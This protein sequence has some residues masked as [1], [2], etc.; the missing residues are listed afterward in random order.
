ML[1]PAFD[2]WRLTETE[3]LVST[4]RVLGLILATATSLV[5]LKLVARITGSR[6]L[7]MVAAAVI[8]LDPTYSFAKVSAV[9]PALFGFLALAAATAF[10]CNRLSL[11][12]GLLGLAVAARPEGLLLVFLALGALMLRVWWDR[13][14]LRLA[15]GEDIPQALRV[16]GLPLLVALGIAAHNAA[17]NGDV[18]PNSY[19]VRHVPMGLFDGGN[20]FNV[21]RGYLWHT[22]YFGGAGSLVM[23]LLLVLSGISALRQAVFRAIPLILFPFALYY[24]LSV[25]VPLESRPWGIATRRYLDPTLPFI[26]VGLVVGIHSAWGLLRRLRRAYTRPS[27]GRLVSLG[28]RPLGLAAALAFLGLVAA[29]VATMPSTW[30]SLTQEFAWN[31]RNV[32]YVNVAMARWIDANLPPDAV[33]GAIDPGAFRYFSNRQVVDLTGVNTYA[34]I[35]K[36]LFEAARQE[37]VDY[38]VARRNLYLDSWPLGREVFSLEDPGRT[39]RGTPSMV[40][41]Q[42]LW[43]REVTLA[44]DSIPHITHIAGLVLLDTVDVGQPASE[45]GHLYRAAPP[46][47]PVERVSRLRTRSGSEI[48]LRDDGRTTTGREELVVRS[49]PGQPLIVVKRYDAALAGDMNVYA[50]G[51][52]VGQWRPP[53]QGYVFGEDTFRIAATH[54]TGSTTR[55]RFEHIAQADSRL[56]SFHYWVYTTGE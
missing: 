29:P 42:A 34:A 47:A 16:A 26:A 45:D 20:L 22:P 19:L 48:N 24:A 54:V 12:G 53:V 31:T 21:L 2:I 52:L 32:E 36:P 41:Y 46:A 44:D 38:I 3:A 25:M 23:L 49:Q 9:E 40:V 28:R 1:S 30:V 43:D 27:P 8:A 17:I 4:A 18:Y 14:D 39:E 6:A 10:Y 35:N 51:L 7:G 11:T 37:G 33:I 15:P 50:D 5:A 55:L 56:T 13:E